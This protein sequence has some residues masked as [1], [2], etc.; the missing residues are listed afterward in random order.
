[1]VE[2]VVE[3]ACTE[4]VDMKD[5]VIWKKEDMVV[6]VTMDEERNMKEENGSDVC[7]WK[8][9]WLWLICLLCWI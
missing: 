8:W 2:D 4:E 9:L 3:V 6:M 1:M 5:M 7:I